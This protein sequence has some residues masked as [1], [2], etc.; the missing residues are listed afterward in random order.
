[1]AHWKLEEKP[2]RRMKQPTKDYLR[3]ELKLAEAEIESK[4]EVIDRQQ[5][6]IQRLRRP[7]WK[8]ILRI[9]A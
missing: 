1:M 8:R 5:G 7:F 9:A 6:E 3:A 2:R 4:Q